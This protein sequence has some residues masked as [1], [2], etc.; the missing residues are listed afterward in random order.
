MPEILKVCARP[1]SDRGI[2]RELIEAVAG[3][4]IDSNTPTRK[5][6]AKRRK[7]APA[8]HG[9]RNVN[10]ENPQKARART[11]RPLQR[12]AITPPGI[13]SKAYP[14]RNEE[15]TQPNS[16]FVQPSSFITTGAATEM[17]TRS[18]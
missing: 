8:P 16:S 11:F 1:N 13:C 5:R 4:V 10:S 14:M 3:K 12:S 15:N 18:T 17:L 7:N 9:V 2:Q 6:T